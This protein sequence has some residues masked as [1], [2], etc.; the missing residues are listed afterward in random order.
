MEQFLF[1]QLLQLTSLVSFVRQ[2]EK[3]QPFF[4][5]LK[6][7]IALLEAR[8]LGREL[9][10]VDLR[11]DGWGE[12]REE[13]E[14]GWDGGVRILKFESRLRLSLSRAK[15]APC[16]SSS[17]SSFASSLT[18]A[19][20]EEGSYSTPTAAWGAISIREVLVCRRKGGTR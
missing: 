2:R 16:S 6:L 15:H 10:D 17:S 12:G 1:F 20:G 9:V 8:Q 5:Y 19:P 11:G 4:S 13:R 7:V 14:W 18:S 3:R